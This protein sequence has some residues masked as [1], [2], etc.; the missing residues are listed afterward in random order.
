MKV[1]LSLEDIQ[2]LFCKEEGIL[3]KYSDTSLKSIEAWLDDK[4]E[5]V[6][7]IEK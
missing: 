7:S 5:W 2:V 3:A 4:K 6:K 1:I